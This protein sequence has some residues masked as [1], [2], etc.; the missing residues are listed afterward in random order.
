MNQKITTII[1]DWGRTI[2]D[3]ERDVLFEGVTELIPEFAK[4]YKLAL[5]S[6]AK[7]DT[8][9]TRRVRIA[10]SG[11]AQFFEHILVGE[12]DKNEMYE[13]LLDNLG[14]EPSKIALVDD[15][16]IRGIAWGNRNGATTIWFR[17]GKFAG[18][19]PDKNTGTPTHII[20]S[21]KELK[22]IL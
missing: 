16:T 7:S 1:F 9:E 2:H 19:L 8:P 17:N 12:H 10:E 4:K 5:V 21:F 3:P 15:R 6:L 20:T 14:I 22:N 18:E 11:I 13:K